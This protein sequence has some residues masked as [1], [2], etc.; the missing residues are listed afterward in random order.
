MWKIGRF[1]L[2]NGGAADSRRLRSFIAMQNL[3]YLRRGFDQIE[4]GLNEALGVP[5]QQPQ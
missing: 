3:F 2:Q 5:A 4:V 1:S